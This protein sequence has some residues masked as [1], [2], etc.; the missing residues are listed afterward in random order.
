MQNHEPK[1][2]ALKDRKLQHRAKGKILL[3]FD[4]VWNTVTIKLTY[5]SQY[6]YATTVESRY[7]NRESQR[8]PLHEPRGEVQAASV[9]ETCPSCAS[10]GQGD[11][12]RVVICSE[13]LVVGKSCQ[14][15]MYFFCRSWSKSAIRSLYGWCFK[16]IFIVATYFAELYMIPVLLLCL[17]IRGFMYRKVEESVRQNNYKFE[18]WTTFI[19]INNNLI[20][21]LFLRNMQIREVKL[22]TLANL[23]KRFLFKKL[24]V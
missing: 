5:K 10:R 3:E 7:Q 8:A 16:K 6:K 14:I 12:G 15:G 21:I 23:K 9:H 11:C 22:K 4:L 24:S 19:L 13:L 20:I 17:F 1:W 18:A 2:F